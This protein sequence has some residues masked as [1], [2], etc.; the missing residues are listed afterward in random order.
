M[1]YST[2]APGITG[3]LLTGLFV[4]FAGAYL[5]HRYW[6][7]KDIVET[8]R[9][10]ADAALKIIDTITRSFENR[11]F[12]QFSF[13][14]ILKERPPSEQELQEYRSAVFQW[15]SEFAANKSSIRFQFGRDKMIEFEEEVHNQLR[16]IS[17]IMLRTHRYGYENLSWLHRMEH[18]Q[19]GNDF[20][21]ARR[22]FFSFLRSLQEAVEEGNIGE[23]RRKR[24]Q[25]V[26]YS[27]ESN[28]KLIQRLLGLKEVN[29]K[30]TP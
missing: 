26:P 6:E 11:Y 13:W 18:N 1:T 23:E 12:A 8:R 19:T 28:W 15:M 9:R 24:E 16:R 14:R 27:S 30:A 3:A 4:A 29:S 22:A 25:K 7:K 10:D 17:D 5:Q 20:E 2:T 21:R